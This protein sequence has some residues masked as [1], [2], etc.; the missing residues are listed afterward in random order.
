MPQDPTDPNW[1]KASSDPTDPDWGMTASR[2]TAQ[3]IAADEPDT[4]WSG[5]LKG[6][7]EGAIGGVTGFAKGLAHSP[8][9]FAQGLVSLLTT[10]PLTTAKETIAAIERLPEAM[11]QAG[12]DPESWGEGVG[13]VTGQT[14][15]GAAAPAVVRGTVRGAR[16][17]GPIAARVAPRLVKH[18]ATA[19]GAYLGGPAGAVVG[20][21]IGD[22]L[23]NAFRRPQP[24]AQG[25]VSVTGYPK[26]VVNQA[27]TPSAVSITGG[28]PPRETAPAAAPVEAA[29]VAPAAP[30]A[31]NPTSGLKAAR[32]AF[33]ALGE[34]PRPAE[35]SNASALIQ[36]GKSPAEA[37]SQVIKNRPLTP[38]GSP[39]ADF[40]ARYGLPSEAERIAAQDLRNAQGK[41]KTP[42]AE[43]ARA[44]RA[45]ALAAPVDEPVTLYHTSTN[46][47]AGGKPKFDA[48]FGDADF[49]KTFDKQE[50]GGHAYEVKL[51][52]DSRVLDLNSGS[53]EARQFMEQMGRAAWPND[54]E[55]SAKLLNGDPSVAGD[56]YEVWTDKDHIMAVLKKMPQYDAVKYQSEYMV[57]ERTLRKLTGR[58]IPSVP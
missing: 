13:D 16:A 22:E 35:I 26:L 45:A 15:I 52:T 28:F 23:V 31:F 34:T 10:N 6:A 18:A 21:G 53:P 4:Y 39:A 1:G 2:A 57:P 43:T 27:T 8:A 42:S 5:A 12:V 19:G 37:V 50:F 20:S 14:M 56:F 58:K 40:A 54:A 51:P 25:A 7:K 33:A 44:R 48:F 36:R 49:Y 38:S 11:R 41:V 32:D 47:L 46:D 9:S 24:E 17:A 29:A 30:A 3:P 55:F